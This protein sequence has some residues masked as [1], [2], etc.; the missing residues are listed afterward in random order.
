MKEIATRQDV[1]SFSIDWNR[2]LE[3]FLLSQSGLS[4]KTVQAYR[5]GVSRFIRF[6]Q[7]QSIDRPLPDDIHVYIRM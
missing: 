5:G 4:Q 1:Q 3:N 7:E 2:Y 6:M